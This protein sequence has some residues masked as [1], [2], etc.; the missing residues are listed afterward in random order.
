MENENNGLPEIKKP[1]LLQE[2]P[3]SKDVKNQEQQNDAN[4]NE[5][6][7]TDQSPEK[8]KNEEKNLELEN[9]NKKPTEK[10]NLP[11]KPQNS[12][13]LCLEDFDYIRNLGKGSF[14]EVVLVKKKSDGKHYAM[15]AIDKNF[16]YKV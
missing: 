2:D 1:L 9:Q 15:K 12:K 13:K 10:K 7:L 3:N 6:I 16:L 11:P 14:G 8:I 4:I 5:L